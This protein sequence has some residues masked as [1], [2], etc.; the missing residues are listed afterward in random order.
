[1]A[2]HIDETWTDDCPSCVNIELRLACV[3]RPVD[4][5]YTA[6]RDAHIEMLSGTAS[7]V[8][9]FASPDQDVQ[10]VPR[11]SAHDQST[12]DVDGLAGDVA[13]LVAGQEAHQIGYFLGRAGAPQRN[14]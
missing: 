4:E 11:L 10:H 1:M 14:V 3:I 5:H 9:H 7:A 8:H 12:A 6:V 13:G 2:V